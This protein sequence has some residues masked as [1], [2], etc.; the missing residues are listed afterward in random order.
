[1]PSHLGPVGIE[2]PKPLHIPNWD[3]SSGRPALELFYSPRPYNT[4]Q[5]FILLHHQPWRLICFTLPIVA[6]KP[7][8]NLRL[9]RS[10][11]SLFRFKPGRSWNRCLVKSLRTLFLA[12]L[13]SNSLKPRP[14]SIFALMSMDRPSDGF[15]TNVTL[16]FFAAL[17]KSSLSPATSG[18]LELGMSMLS[19]FMPLFEDSKVAVLSF[20]CFN[21]VS[22]LTLLPLSMSS[23]GRN[24]SG[25]TGLWLG[26]LVLFRQSSLD[27]VAAG[28]L[29]K[30]D[31]LL[32]VCSEFDDAP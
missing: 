1:M 24:L 5:P 32:A 28:V 20:I 27:V 25:R 18:A 14:T 31:I 23:P 22:A 12:Q 11:P 9:H 3:S 4:I 10:L 26:S 16:S 19:V 17:L 29:R 30:F 8:I 15:S 6:L 7:S 2:I 13:C 21:I